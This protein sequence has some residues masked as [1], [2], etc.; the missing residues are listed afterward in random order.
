MSLVDDRVLEF[1]RENGSG[2]PTKMKE[3]G[4]IRY[5]PEYIAERCRELTKRGLLQHLGNG[6]Y[7]ITEDGERYLDGELDT[8]ELQSPD[9][10]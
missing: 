5:T 1:V 7:V 3:E 9:D 2:S 6:V 10:E 8:A 4:R